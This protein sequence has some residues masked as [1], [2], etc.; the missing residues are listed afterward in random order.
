M[1]QLWKIQERKQQI[2]YTI[3]SR[4]FWNFLLIVFEFL[5]ISVYLILLTILLG[6]TTRNN[7]FWQR[8][9]LFHQLALFC[10][11]DW[12]QIEISS[13]DQQ[14]FAV[15][16]LQGTE[17]NLD[18]SDSGSDRHHRTFYGFLN[19]SFDQVFWMKTNHSKENEGV[20]AL[21]P[22]EGGAGSAGLA[23][24]NTEENILHTLSSSFSV[25]L[26][27]VSQLKCLFFHAIIKIPL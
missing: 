8:P 13:Q 5:W 7:H 20:W 27:K 14:Q 15:W 23:I 6:S 19:L 21:W 16:W 22:N 24:S 1:D 10:L 18:D 26:Q 12:S 4:F 11:W 25:L 2:T 3:W 9:M 17:N